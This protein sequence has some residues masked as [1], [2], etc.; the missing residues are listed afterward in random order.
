MY[1]VTATVR[2]KF[3]QFMTYFYY[4]YCWCLKSVLNCLISSTTFKNN[5]LGRW[6][7]K[8]HIGKLLDFFLELDVS[9]VLKVTKFGTMMP[10]ALLFQIIFLEY[11]K[12]CE[13]L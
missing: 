8:K 5:S 13:S 2:K 6:A 3:V 7:S 12:G 10:E 11:N 4:Y 1:S 9:E